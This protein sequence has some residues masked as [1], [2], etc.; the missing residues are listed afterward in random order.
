MDDARIVELFWHRSEDAISELSAKYGCTL[1]RVA[2]N[3]LGSRPDAEE[4]VNDTYL[5]CWNTIPPE[6]P[7]QL[8]AYACRIVRNISISKHRKN[9]A[10]KRRGNSYER[11]LDELEASLTSPETVEEAISSDELS[12]TINDFLGRLDTES[13]VMFVRRYYYS[14]PVSEI[15]KLT[16]MSGR[17]VSVKLF[18]IREKL[19]AHLI[20]RGYMR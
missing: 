16:G 3:I 8:L 18:R 7:K 2:E 20:E 6:N 11:A 15:A 12:R 1:S 17:A 9:T 10:M 14:D 13:R 4:C 5:A 19:R